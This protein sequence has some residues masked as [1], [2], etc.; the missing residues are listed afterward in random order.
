M[1]TNDSAVTEKARQA[2]LAKEKRQAQDT[3]RKTSFFIGTAV[4]LL[5][6]AIIYFFKFR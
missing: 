5:V 6:A 1:S 3:A 2:W 4:V